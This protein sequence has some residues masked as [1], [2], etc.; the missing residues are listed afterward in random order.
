MH[1][2][3]K[4]FFALSVMICML[5]VIGGSMGAF[6]TGVALT[7]LAAILVF[8]AAASGDEKKS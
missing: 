1:T 5:G 8:V 3:A 4:M 7:L 2:F 6:F